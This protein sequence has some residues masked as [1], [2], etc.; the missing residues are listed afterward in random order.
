M[1]FCCC[2]GSIKI[3]NSLVF[4][5]VIPALVALY[6][7]IEVLVSSRCTLGIFKWVII[8]IP[9][10]LFKEYKLSKMGNTGYVNY[11]WMQNAIVKGEGGKQ[12]VR[13]SCN[14]NILKF[15]AKTFI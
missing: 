1:F 11:E 3:Y 13:I 15:V 5:Y 12:A 9:L 10:E 14:T 6:R 8:L 7:Q 4:G 2:K